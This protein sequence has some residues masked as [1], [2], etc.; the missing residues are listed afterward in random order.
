KANIYRENADPILLGIEDRLIATLD[1]LGRS[2]H[3]VDGEPL[4]VV[5]DAPVRSLRPRRSGALA[6]ARLR[7]DERVFAPLRRDVPSRARA[8]E[9]Q[10]VLP[11]RDQVSVAQTM[12]PDPTAVHEAAVRAVQIEQQPTVARLHEEIL[13]TAHVAAVE[14]DVARRVAAEHHTRPNERDLGDRAAAA[15]DD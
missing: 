4:A 12:L 10:L 11:D 15:R 6:D 14:A 8:R 2:A 9:P 7:T 1:A 5:R 3:L 13:I